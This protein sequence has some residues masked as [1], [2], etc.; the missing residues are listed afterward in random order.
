MISPFSSGFAWWFK[1]GGR[2]LSDEDTCETGRS[3]RKAAEQSTV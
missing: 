1:S 2:E 3:Q